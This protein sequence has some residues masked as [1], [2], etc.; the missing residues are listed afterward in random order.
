MVDYLANEGVSSTCDKIDSDWNY[1]VNTSLKHECLTL[2]QT[3]YNSLDGLFDKTTGE[4]MHR[5]DHQDTCP[6]THSSRHFP[7]GIN[8][9]NETLHSPFPCVLQ[10][11]WQRVEVRMMVQVQRRLQLPFSTMNYPREMLIQGVQME[12]L[13]NFKPTR[14]Q[15]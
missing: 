1:L 10:R 11:F 9:Y 13:L 8:P 7:L 14:V 5:Q 4:S 6:V 15:V 12:D 3:N 2:A